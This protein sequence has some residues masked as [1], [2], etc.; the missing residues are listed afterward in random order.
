MFGR[1]VTGTKIGGYVLRS[2]G[3][4][5]SHTTTIAIHRH[6]GTIRLVKITLKPVHHHRIVI[7]SVRHHHSRIVVHHT[8]SV[9]GR[10]N[11]GAHIHPRIRTHHHYSWWLGKSIHH[12]SGLNVVIHTIPVHVCGTNSVVRKATVIVH[13]S[14]TAH[15]IV[16]SH[17]HIS[18]LVRHWLIHHYAA[19]NCIIS[20]HIPHHHSNIVTT[21]H[22][23]VIHDR[24]LRRCAGGH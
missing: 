15:Y 22:G 10:I 3:V 13:G 6:E 23:R 8:H 11:V 18:I 19:T 17:H 9:I 24:W 1:S 5:D 14:S 12:H 20:I 2:G 7:I 16:V 21:I 4:I